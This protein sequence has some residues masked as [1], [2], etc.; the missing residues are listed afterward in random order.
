MNIKCGFFFYLEEQNT[1]ETWGKWE[2]TEGAN[3]T[4]IACI[5]S[6]ERKKHTQREREILAAQFLNN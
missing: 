5:D 2:E 1:L 6:A 4:L 3:K